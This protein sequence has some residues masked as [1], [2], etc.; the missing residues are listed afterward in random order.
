MHSMNFIH[1]DYQGSLYFTSLS[2]YVYWQVLQ[3]KFEDFLHDLNSSEDRVTSVT[4][5]ATEMIEAKHFVSEAIKKRSEEVVHQWN[6]LKEVA[7]ARQEVR[8]ILRFMKCVYWQI[9]GCF[10]CVI[11]YS[12]GLGSC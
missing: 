2:L 11:V 3:Q 12:V 9:S 10:L 4:A 7:K 8:L 1:V 5:M 6:E